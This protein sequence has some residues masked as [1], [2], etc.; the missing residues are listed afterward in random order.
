MSTETTRDEIKHGRYRSR[1]V[2]I[3]AA[4]LLIV[5]GVVLALLRPDPTAPSSDQGFEWVT[6]SPEEQ[7]MD[8][9]KLEAMMAYIDE[10]DMAVDSVVVVRHG[11]I[12]FEKYGPGYTPSRR[13]P[14]YSVTKSVTSMLV[15]IAIDQ[16]F[17]EGLDVPV[18]RLLPDYASA[19][20]DPR[21]EQIT[22]ENLLTMSDGI[23]WREHEYS[24][25][26]QRN[27][28]GQAELSADAVQ[29]VLDQPM[30]R[31]PSE[32]W[33]YNSGASILLGAILEEATGRNLVLFAREV[34]FDPIG[35]GTVYWEQMSDGHY[36]TG[37][38]LHMAPRDMARLGY[39]M[40]HNGNWNGEQIVPAEW[41]ARSTRTH[42]QAYGPYGYGYQWW[43]LPAGQGYRAEGL[44]QQYIYVL[45][46]ADMV[47]VVTADIR[48]G[49]LHSVDGLVNALVLPACTD[50]PQ[51][52]S[53]A[54][55]EAHGIT[56][57]YP[58]RF[59]S[60]ER[61]ILG[62]E[63]VSDASGMLRLTSTWEPIEVLLVL[64]S[65]VE[66][67]EDAWS[68]LDMYLA[69]I[70]EDGTR[71]MPGESA[72]GEKDGHAMA[73]RFSEMA[74]EEGTVPTISGVWI[75][76]TSARAF[77]VTYLTTEKVM[78]EELR[79]ALERYLEGLKCHLMPKV[80]SNESH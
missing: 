4:I 18:T 39:L 41:V 8:S 60:E 9:R 34:L 69:G 29:F 71:V 57:A 36:Q 38:G 35:V 56:L 59:A 14:L 44:Y 32:A 27:I 1:L 54:T 79:A 12:V 2:W 28:V 53:H 17:I 25:E 66:G 48:G 78:P 13:H 76:D 26:D 65:Q 43:I 77:A 70:E 6:S 73:L 49:S 33:A 62:Q 55:Y 3:V 15:G 21:R 11:R 24:Y 80:T 67:D 74:F 52:A 75:C 7:G 40:L 50:L 16:G 63:A 68:F 5:G 23:D 72:E 42:Y 61:P 46:E 20:P 30:A 51:P 10:H 45:P 37:G 19:N 31:A 58:T 64:W 22:L 47:V